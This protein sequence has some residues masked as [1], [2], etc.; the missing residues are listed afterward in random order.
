M[1]LY[2]SK[3]CWLLRYS[4][5]ARVLYD[6]GQ[7]IFLPPTNKIAEFESKKYAQK[8]GRSNGRT[9]CCWDFCSFPIVITY[10]LA[11]ETHSTKL[12]RAPPPTLQRF[13]KL[14]SKEYSFLVI[15]WSN[16]LLKTLFKWLKKCVDAPPEARA[17]TCPSPLA[18]PLLRYLKNSQTRGYP[19]LENDSK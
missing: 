2:L 11:L 5:V 4:G 14:F 3:S 18:T 8:R 1:C 12:S 16:F 15:F 19:V 17:P 13:L 9:F 7:K 6:L 10:F